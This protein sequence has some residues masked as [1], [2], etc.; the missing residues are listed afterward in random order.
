MGGHTKIQLKNRSQE[1]I[2][3]CNESLKVAGVRQEYRFYSEQDTLDEYEAF[4]K[5]EGVYPEHLFPRD[6][7]NSLEDFQRYWSTEAL[8]ES[9]V[10]PVGAL[11]CD[12]YFGRMSQR[13]MKNLV[14]WCADNYNLI[15]TT[16]GSWPTLVERGGTTFDKLVLKAL[17]V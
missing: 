7:I 2:D 3:A 15:E 5:S 8:G 9:F 13:A 16:S 4:V 6:Q 10:S 1:H 12:C 14:R 17:A 11:T